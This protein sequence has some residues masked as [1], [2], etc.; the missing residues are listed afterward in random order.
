MTIFL[1]PGLA[2]F[3]LYYFSDGPYL[4]Y[5]AAAGFVLA[6]VHLASRPLA[7]QRTSMRSRSLRRCSSW[8]RRAPPPASPR[9]CEP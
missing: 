3:L 8:F 5:I 7:T 2:F 1:A 6:G 4:A 9:S